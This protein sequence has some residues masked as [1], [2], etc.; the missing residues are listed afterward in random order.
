MAVNRRAIALLPLLALA[1]CIL[2]PLA[3]SAFAADKPDPTPREATTLPTKPPEP[4]PTPE[5]GI[6]M[7]ATVT[8]YCTCVECCGEWSAEHPSRIGTDYQQLTASGTVP[9][10]CRTIA[11]DPDVIP[12]GSYV[13]IGGGVYIAEDT[14][15][16][17]SGNHI[18]IF[19]PDHEE[20]D[21]F[22]TK[23]MEVTVYTPERFSAWE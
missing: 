11:V 16:Y 12:L 10:R 18:D 5:P 1:L 17:V 22:G 8:A 7:R 2:C 15:S 13:M 19:I 20:A 21:V 9:T 6:T 3:H 4:S 14:G 23:E